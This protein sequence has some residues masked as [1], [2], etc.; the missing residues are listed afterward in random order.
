MATSMSTYTHNTISQLELNNTTFDIMDAKTRDTVSNLVTQ[1]NNLEAAVV[2]HP[3]SGTT[4]LTSA[5]V[6]A[7]NANNNRII[8]NGKTSS[9]D[10]SI[11]ALDGDIRLRNNSGSGTIVWKIPGTIESTVNT[12]KGG[13]INGSFGNL[14]ASHQCY[15]IAGTVINSANTTYYNKRIGLLIN[16]NNL[17]LYNFTDQQSIWTAAMIDSTSAM[18]IRENS[19]ILKS[20][21]YKRTDTVTSG[22]G[23]LGNSRVI[24][25]D[26]QTTATAL[27]QIYPQVT[28]G[29]KSLILICYNGGASDTTSNYF[30]V[31]VNESG[32]A[33]YGMSS[34]A[35]FRNA[36]GIGRES[37]TITLNSTNNNN[38]NAKI[39]YVYNGL[40]VSIKVTDIQLKGTVPSGK[41]MIIANLNTTA[42]SKLIPTWT[43]NV[44][45]PISWTNEKSG[46]FLTLNNSATGNTQLVN[47]SGNA[48]SLSKGDLYIFNRSGTAIPANSTYFNGFITFNL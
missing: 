12:I 10:Y 17:S 13:N 5:T 1:V 3:T 32:A 24:F 31:G 20:T 16:N 8:I 40:T 15:N 38:S 19:I 7:D 18:T 2:K 47:T 14:T 43:P 39:Y 21:N 23:T 46:I 41:G 29:G 48:V 44:S 11:I 30:S 4:A 28:T 9:T 35:N 22:S 27:A 45:N 26:S 25:R 33:T 36:I 37:G 34:P 42:L 6:Y